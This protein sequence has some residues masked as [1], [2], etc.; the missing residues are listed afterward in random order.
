[1]HPPGADAA[2]HH[3]AYTAVL[4]NTPFHSERHCQSHVGAPVTRP[5]A[6]AGVIRQLGKRCQPGRGIPTLPPPPPNPL[7][8]AP[9]PHP[10]PG[11]PLNNSVRLMSCLSRAAVSSALGGT[12][13]FL[14]GRAAPSAAAS[15]DT[16]GWAAGCSRGRGVPSVKRRGAWSAGQSRQEPA[17]LPSKVW[18]ETHRAAPPALV[19]AGRAGWRVG[20]HAHDC[21]LRRHRHAAPHALGAAAHAAHVSRATDRPV[22]GGCAQRH[23]KARSRSLITW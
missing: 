4:C 21:V 17:A 2:P 8:L 14:P 9:L 23:A 20:C 12:G 7:L 22:R 11:A 16:C 6:A 3:T 15:A 1:M 19:R 5:P 18:T 10:W 13:L